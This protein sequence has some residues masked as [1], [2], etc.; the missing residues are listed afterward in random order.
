MHYTAIADTD[1]GIRKGTNQDSMLIKHAS[2]VKGEVLLAVVC[3][4]MG[5]LEKG[6]L[7]S[8]TVVR[9]FSEWFTRE[10][11]YELESPDMGV[12]GEKWALMLKELN[13]KI[14]EYGKEYGGS[15]GTTFTG[16]LFI[17]DDFVIGHV[18]DTR[19]YHID[20]TVSQLTEDHT[21]IAREIRLG[22]MSVAQAKVDKRRNMLLQCIGASKEVTPQ[23]IC[24]KVKSGTYL[25]CSDGFRHEVTE[26]EIQEELQ[27]SGLR[28][29]QIMH[30]KVCKLIELVKSRQE[31]DN[32]SAILIK[33]E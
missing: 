16:I 1:I 9:H 24:G 31:N 23:L 12:I 30:N 28:D 33:A 5:G 22:N 27:L 13:V 14:M 26:K 2:T 17:N 6:E 19:L 7:A 20:D 21:Y 8:A 32:I 11:P 3:D 29:K 18:G 15:L 10:L 25:L 4:G